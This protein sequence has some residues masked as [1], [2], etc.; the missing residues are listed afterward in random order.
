[1]TW[2]VD[3][4]RTVK[5]ALLGSWPGTISAWGEDAIDAYTFVLQARG[6]T[7]EDVVRAILTWP[8]GS[9]FPPSAPNLA[10]AAMTDP[11]APTFAEACVL[12]YG[13]GG[14]FRA[15]AASKGSWEDGERAAADVQAMR[16]RL[17]RCHD[18][19]RAF[20][21]AQ[22]FDRLHAIG[23]DDDEHG[24]ARRKL[25]E[26]QWDRFVESSDARRVA[27]LAAGARRGALGQMDPLA[28]LPRRGIDAG[29]RA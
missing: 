5:R 15:R 27:S 11:S 7:G 16:D 29:D 25:L 17:G 9:D 13:P 21:A 12:L 24:G 19:V 20:V 1:M 2:T 14:V 22:G 4:S 10:A 6:L 23:L 8:S 26:D 28:A 18:R 3:E